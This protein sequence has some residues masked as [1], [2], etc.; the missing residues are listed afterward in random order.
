MNQINKILPDD[1]LDIVFHYKKQ[2]EL[3]DLVSE[4]KSDNVLSKCPNCTKTKICMRQCH[5]CNNFICYECRYADLNDEIVDKNTFDLF[6]KCDDCDM[7]DRY[8]DIAQ[9]SEED[10]DSESDYYNEE[11]YARCWSDVF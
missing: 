3:I 2:L 1:I 11:R 9:H 6:Y 4:L 10:Y 7:N 5:T 8:W